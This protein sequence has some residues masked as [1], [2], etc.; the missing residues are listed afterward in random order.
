MSSCPVVMAVNWDQAPAFQRKRRSGRAFQGWSG[1]RMTIRSRNPWLLGSMALSLILSLSVVFIPPLRAV[2]GFSA[3]SGGQALA[4]L[5]LAL[6][7]LP[8][9]ELVK[10]IQR[11]LGK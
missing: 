6:L 2:F 5:G 11:T 8:I 9:V 10:L 1:W 4:S 7:I 3:L